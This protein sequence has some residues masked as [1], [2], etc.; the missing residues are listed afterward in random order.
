[1]NTF[2]R[3]IGLTLKGL[4][5]REAAGDA[6]IALQ[7]KVYRSYSKNHPGYEPHENLVGLWITRRAT[8]RNK[9]LFEEMT[10][11]LPSMMDSIPEVLLDSLA[12]RYHSMIP[13]AFMETML[14]AC[15]PPPDNARALGLY[16]IY[17]E[18]PGIVHA[19]PKFAIEF[20]SLMSPVFTAVE[21]GD[22]YE[23]YQCYNPQM[24]AEG[25]EYIRAM[26]DANRGHPMADI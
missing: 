21:N 12:P 22:I 26:L 3:V 23:L 16:F 6:I 19:Y 20:E 2:L 24:A 1:M 13:M 10:A 17:K 7:E 18:L 4:I 14:Y 5:S 25:N 8:P 15:I 9:R 11:S